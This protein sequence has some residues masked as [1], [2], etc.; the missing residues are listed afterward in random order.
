MKKFLMQIT[1][2]RRRL[3][4]CGLLGLLTGF[5]LLLVATQSMI[6]GSS[7]LHYR[8]LLWNLFLAWIPLGFALSAYERHR[9]GQRGIIVFLLGILWLLFFP[10]APYIISDFVHLVWRKSTP[11]EF[12]FWHYLVTLTSF[13]WTGLLLGFASLY[14]MQRIIQERIGRVMGWLITFSVLALSGFGIY[15]GRFGRWNSWDVLREPVGLTM[16]IANRLL[17]PL[18]HYETW[19]FTLLFGGLLIFLYVVMYSFLILV[20]EHRSDSTRITQGLST[21]THQV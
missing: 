7:F 17:D 9:R 1:G 16:D 5:C 12:R 19:G 2:N 21:T 6:P 8:F 15:L 3:V 13:A 20:Q 14:L 18:A 11:D 10:N 4:V